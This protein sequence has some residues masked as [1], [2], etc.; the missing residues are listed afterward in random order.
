MN[1]PVPAAKP[2]ENRKRAERESDKS[3]NWRARDNTRPGP[4]HVRWADEE[5]AQEEAKLQDWP[6]PADMEE[7]NRFLS[8]ISIFKDEIWDFSRHIKPLVNVLKDRKFEW[9]SAQQGAFDEIKHTIIL[10]MQRKA[11]ER[12]R[13][14]KER[15]DLI[16]DNGK[17]PQ[18]SKVITLDD[19]YPDENPGQGA[20]TTHVDPA[21]KN[22]GR[23]LQRNEPSPVAPERAYRV[24]SA[25]DRA[26]TEDAIVD[27]I[28]GSASSLTASDIAAVAP[29]VNRK[30]K[31]RLTKTRVPIKQPPAK[32]ALAQ[33]IDQENADLPGLLDDN[34]GDEDSDDEDEPFKLD[35]DALDVAELPTVTS[36]YVA[37]ENEYG[38]PA[39]SIIV[40]DPYEQYLD[41]L[42]EGEVPKQVYVAR[43]SDSLRA[44]WPLVFG[45]ER[46]ESVLDSGS[47][48][49]S[50][51]LKTAQRLNIPW[52]PDVQIFMQSANGQL[53]KSAG[54]ARNVAFLF[55]D[56]TLYLQVHVIDQP[57]Y[58]I[59]LGRPFE[60]LTESNV[61]N[62]RDGTQTLTLTDPNSG[63]RVTIPTSVRGAL[64]MAKQP[65]DNTSRRATVEE[66]EDEDEA[67]ARPK[68]GAT[69]PP[70]Q[71]GPGFQ[72]SSR[73]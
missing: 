14:E 62:K 2:P 48:I 20:F 44:I 17:Y 59:L 9:G 70:E 64:S 68:R 57:A 10:W 24:V 7:L 22:L 8:W 38:I 23:R 12:E 56:I 36:L 61:Q 65:K 32:E 39:G 28:M 18:I 21:D 27:Q 73:N 49:V 1:T 43:E 13:D 46:V 54:L 58:E 40:P 53:K 71:E 67:K 45:K 34:S 63:R 29:G 31:M 25:S 26:K 5:K 16:P 15:G 6:V 69:A 33:E 30:L 35:W 37:A 51:A 52:N 72:R 55:G 19:V 42:K 3:D 47:Q 4:W 50:M 66:V 60:V 11:R 41:S